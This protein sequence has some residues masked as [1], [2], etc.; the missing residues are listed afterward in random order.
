MCLRIVFVLYPYM[1]H[2]CM[3]YVHWYMKCVH[4]CMKCVHWCVKCVHWYMECVQW[5]VKCVHWYMECVQWCV[6]CVPWCVHWSMKSEICLMVHGNMSQEITVAWP[7]QSLNLLGGCR[8]KSSFQPICS[9]LRFCL[10][11]A[12][13]FS[14]ITKD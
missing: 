11:N 5:F 12:V 1:F 9:K 14:I 3:K 8:Q 6:K 7:V 10:L 4:W 13:V 2:W